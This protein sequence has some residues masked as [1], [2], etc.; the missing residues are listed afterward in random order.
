MRERP[1]RRQFSAEFKQR[2]V[3]EAEV[4]RASGDPGAIGALLRREGIY[5]SHL[6][7]WRRQAAEGEIGSLAPKKRGPK[8]KAQDPSAKELAKLQRQNAKLLDD[9]RKAHI[10]IDVQKKLA[11]LLG[12]ELPETEPLTPLDEVIAR[13]EKL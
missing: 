3:R 11:A 13:N 6:A 12:R 5:S 9:L 1:V 10:I 4:A 2:V 7:T 8:P